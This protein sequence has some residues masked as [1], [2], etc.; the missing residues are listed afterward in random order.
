MVLGGGIGVETE[1]CGTDAEDEED[2]EEVVSAFLGY[3][4]SNEDLESA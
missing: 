2:E 1:V 3:A 4:Y